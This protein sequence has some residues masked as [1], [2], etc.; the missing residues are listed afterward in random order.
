MHSRRRM[1]AIVIGVVAASLGVAAPAGASDDVQPGESIQAAIDDALPGDTI[2]IAPGEFRENVT[3]T[4][5]DI[6]LR[7]SGSGRHGTV[8]MPS[9]SPATSPCEPP[10]VSGICVHGSND[11]GGPAVSDVTII[12]RSLKLLR[13]IEA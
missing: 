10:E 1:S 7:G 2:T 13:R 5:D 3:I 12:S 6:T 4:T 9:L 8:L 11:E